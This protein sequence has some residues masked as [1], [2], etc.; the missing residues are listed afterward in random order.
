MSITL[1]TTLIAGGLA[2]L[3]NNGCVL[4]LMATGMIYQWFLVL[5]LIDLAIHLAGLTWLN[6]C[7][8]YLFGF[9]QYFVLF[10]II[11]RLIYGRRAAS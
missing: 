7:L 2:F 10:W 5:P 9:F 8:L 3:V 11:I 4:L 6:L 1:K